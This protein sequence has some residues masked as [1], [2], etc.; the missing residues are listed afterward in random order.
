[1]A[2]KDVVKELKQVMFDKDYDRA[3]SIIESLSGSE[4]ISVLLHLRFSS[5]GHDSLID[6]IKNRV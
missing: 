3:I 5:A 2:V 1:M 6:M 4:R